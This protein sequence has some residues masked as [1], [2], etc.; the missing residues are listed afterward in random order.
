MKQPF[1]ALAFLVSITGCSSHDQYMTNRAE[2][3]CAVWERC[4]LLGVIGYDDFDECFDELYDEAAEAEAAAG[5][6]PDYD[7][8]AAGRCVDDLNELS[9]DSNFETPSACLEVC[10]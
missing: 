2:A 7:S 9:C 10:G 8:A 3:T 4:G 1:T 5:E 6:C